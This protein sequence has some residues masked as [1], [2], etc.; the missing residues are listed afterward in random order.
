MR[1][2]HAIAIASVAA[3]GVAGCG[4]HASTPR[5][6]STTASA[7]TITTAATRPVAKPKPPPV[8]RLQL[9]LPLIG[10]SSAPTV[11]YETT[12]AKPTVR[13]VVSPASA[14]VY[15]RA[16]DGTH[17]AL[18]PRADGR[19]AVR[20]KLSPGTNSLQFTAA[21]LGSQ[22]R[23]AQLA[24]TW[25]GSAAAARQ[26]AIY[27]DPA[28]YLPAAS[29]G[30]NRKLKG[31]GKLPPVPAAP[32]PRV[33]VSFSL[34]TI[35]APPPPPIGGTGKW[36]AGFELTEYYPALESWFT[37]RAVSAPGLS[38]PHRID[39]LYSARGLSMEGD[40][41]GLDGHQYHIDNL[42]SGGWL[43]AGGSRGAKFGVGASAPFWR[44]GGFWRSSSGQLTFPLANGNW[45][46]GVG[47]PVRAPAGGHLVR[48]RA[49]AAARIHAQRRRRPAH[50]PRGQPHLHPRLRRRQRRLV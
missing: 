9:Q 46:S 29:A 10:L 34:H 15:M 25:R 42:G 16:P 27:A 5:A 33:T 26:R 32:S 20:A 38:A 39:W 49:I 24:I 45:S 6:R 3:A 14:T 36:L 23:N 50:D 2:R 31:V 18:N 28:K 7:A 30:I 48:P 44:T 12:A 4:G 43:T 41:I 11:R 13:G 8:L 35:K 47:R 37:G 22:T 17:I 21:L 19:F 40:G 1:S